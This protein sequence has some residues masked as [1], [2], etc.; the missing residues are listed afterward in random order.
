MAAPKIDCIPRENEMYAVLCKALTTRE[1]CKQQSNH[2]RWIAEVPDSV[3]PEGD[4]Q[5][6]VVN[7]HSGYYVTKDFTWGYPM[8][9]YCQL[10][11][12]YDADYDIMGH[13]LGLPA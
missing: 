4:G 6:W 2:C 10:A 12:T 9:F 5:Y 7:A 3:Q 1:E 11:G 8:Y 13:L